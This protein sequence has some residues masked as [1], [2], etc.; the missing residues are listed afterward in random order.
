MENLIITLGYQ[1]L[2][3]A[4]VAGSGNFLFGG[5][6]AL[7]VPDFY[8]ATTQTTQALWNFIMGE[9]GSR[10]LYQ[11]DRQPAEHVSWEEALVFL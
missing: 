10:F 2:E 3:L 7:T 1:T 11:G 9:D 6:Q 5:Q 4:F 8:I